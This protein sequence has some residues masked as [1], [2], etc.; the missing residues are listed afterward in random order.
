[1]VKKLLEVNR[2]SATENKAVI[3]TVK[4]LMQQNGFTY[5]E[6]S[7]QSGVSIGGLIGIRKE[8]KVTPNVATKIAH[9]FE[10]ENWKSMIGQS[11]PR[12]LSKKQQGE[13]SAKM[14]YL[15][16]RVKVLERQ[17]EQITAQTGIKKGHTNKNV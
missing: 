8:T 14:E 15:E 16:S 12:L 3:K 6:L 10:Y 17:I 4:Q 7:R 1:M 2:L 11:V 13:L 9:A 5:H